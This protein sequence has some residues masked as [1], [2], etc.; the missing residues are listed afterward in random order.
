MSLDDIKI[1]IFPS[2]SI[3]QS[4][5]AYVNL[6]IPLP[7]EQQSVNLKITG[8]RIM[9]DSYHAHSCGYRV[10]PPSIKSYNKYKEI[11]FFQ[12]PEFWSKLENKILNEYEKTI[13]ED[14]MSNS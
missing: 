5:L 1:E 3:N 7:I 14:E 12:N 2:K 8:F 6:T 10:R 9:T 11:I 13:L 4:T